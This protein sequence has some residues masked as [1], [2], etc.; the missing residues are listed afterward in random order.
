M[1]QKYAT[2]DL[3]KRQRTRKQQ[4]QGQGKT[5]QARKSQKEDLIMKR[6]FDINELKN[7]QKRQD[8][9][10]KHLFKAMRDMEIKEGYW[11]IEAIQFKAAKKARALENILETIENYPELFKD[12][13]QP[14]EED[15]SWTELDITLEDVL[16]ELDEDEG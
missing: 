5:S 7:E 12:I 2:M 13:E 11:E 3:S 10:A 8:S 9:I 4:K 14:K 16:A 1:Q 15:D 6:I